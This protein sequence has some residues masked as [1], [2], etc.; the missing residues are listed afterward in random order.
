MAVFFALLSGA[1]T[2]FG[3]LVGYRVGFAIGARDGIG[4]GRESMR[5]T[6]ER[7]LGLA[8]MELIARESGASSE[9]VDMVMTL[10]R[11]TE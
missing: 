3:I 4:R 8:R 7:I 10:L 6:F 9:L 2:A 5:A 11:E 1:G